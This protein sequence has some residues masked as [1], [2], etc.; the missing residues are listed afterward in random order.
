[1]SMD[2]RV[3]TVLL[4]Q[5][6]ADGATFHVLK[7][8]TDALGGGIRI[9]AASAVETASGQ[10]SGTAYALQLL[11]YSNAGTP[12]VNGTISSANVG[13]TA[14]PLAAG[15]PQIW[16]L[17]SNYSFLDAGESLVVKYSEEG[18]A[19]NPTACSVT[20]HYLLGK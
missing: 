5:T 4:P 8:P 10:T 9:V 13:G 14:S 19:T 3:T 16:T 2:T 7:A 11:K 1:M 20:I 6:C 18:G 15:V 17:N 12:A